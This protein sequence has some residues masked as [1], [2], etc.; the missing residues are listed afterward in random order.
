MGQFGVDWEGPVPPD[1]SDETVIV[2][3]TEC[4]LTSADME[5]LQVAIPPLAQSAQYGMDLYEKT[6]QFVS[7]KIG[8]P[9]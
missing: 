7:Y 8:V 2:P 1:D 5:E 9:L 3:E 6:L 4:P